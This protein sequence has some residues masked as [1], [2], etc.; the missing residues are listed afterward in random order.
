MIG[1]LLDGRGAGA[2]AMPEDAACAVAVRLGEAGIPSLVIRD[3]GVEKND[4]ADQLLPGDTTD[5]PT[6]EPSLA[7]ERV[8]KAWSLGQDQLIYVAADR[9]KLKE[10]TASDATLV[11]VSESHD[12]EADLT[13]DSLSR[14]L[15]LAASE[16]TA[17][18]L[19]MRFIL[20]QIAR[21]AHPYVRDDADATNP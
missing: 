20:M 6:V 13:I 18:L 14:I 12:N 16:Y 10:A 3:D 9:H 5:L 8:A 19:E 2:V 15:E 17:G 1:V 11:L 4:V 21:N 7:I